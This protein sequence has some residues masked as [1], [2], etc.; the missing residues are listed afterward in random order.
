[1]KMTFI[2]L[3]FIIFIFIHCGQSPVTST[4]DLSY[5]PLNV[6][7]IT[8]LIFVRDSSTILL[9]I[10]GTKKRADHTT[11]YQGVWL[12]GK[13]EYDTSYYF[14]DDGYYTS[15]QLD[16]V[17]YD[18]SLVD[19]NPFAEQRLAK[20]F[21]QENDTWIH[22]VGD[23]DPVSWVAHALGSIEVPAGTFNDVFAF[24]LDGI[25]T[26]VYGKGVGWLGTASFVSDTGLD[27]ICTY[28][29][30]KNNENGHL[31]QAKNPEPGPII[32]NQKKRV[33]NYLNQILFESGGSYLI[34]GQKN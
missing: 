13:Y 19:I 26:T 20:S 2:P 8:Q 15:T 18:S 6:G 25:L 11:V 21:P 4:Y 28:K 33:T 27:F 16:I 23:P 14:I 5:T 17:T 12:Y 1:M 29:K 30:V 9:E 34:N 32:L 3:I 10:T 22:T 7:D 31:W 24:T